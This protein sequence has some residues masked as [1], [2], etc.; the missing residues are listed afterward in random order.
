MT[1]PDFW[2]EGI[3]GQNTVGSLPLSENGF[4][5][6]FLILFASFVMGGIALKLIKIFL[7]LEHPLQ[8]KISFWTNN[9]IWMGVL[10]LFWWLFNQWGP[11]LF[12]GSK[13]WLLVGLVWTLG[14]LYL[15]IK[16]FIADYRLELAYFRRRYSQTEVT[17]SK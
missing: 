14:L 4:R 9:L 1:K 8:S 13:F 15:V 5:N 11:L 12:I 6:F 2:L 16:Y 17:K 7:P 10:G 3:A